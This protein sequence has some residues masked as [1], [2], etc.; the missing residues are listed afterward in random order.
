MGSIANAVAVA[1]GKGGV[2]KSTTASHVAG[3]AADSGWKV[4]VVDADSQ[5]NTSRDLGYVP[6]GGVGLAEALLG[7]AQ[8]APITSEQRPNLDYVAGG[9]A[10]VGAA[11]EL[12]N[13]LATA[14]FTAIQAF[15]RALAPIAG[16]YNLIIVDTGPGDHVLRKVVLA[17]TRYVIVPCK[18][19]QSSIPDG[20]ANLLRSVNELRDQLNPELEILGI[21]LGP[22]RATETRRLARARARAGEVLGSEDVLFQ[23][24][25]RD[26]GKIAD[27]CRE[28]G[29]IATE[30]EVR[31][32]QAQATKTPWF[33]LSK[34]DR[35][36]AR[37]SFEF[38]KPGA[39]AGLAKDWADLTNEILERYASR[40]AD[41][42]AA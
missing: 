9:E 7:R 39:A 41:S 30:Y 32:Q 14:D 29:I 13:K 27:D 25:I 18:T 12:G 19:D 1:N 37:L 23:H 26:N 40:Q 34:A 31:A 33:K 17:A 42:S 3:I 10:L 28:L 38:S 4:L 36:A 24:S 8:L 16:D 11:Q 15:S 6:D 22:V 20:L 5:G 2:L 21:V 35:E